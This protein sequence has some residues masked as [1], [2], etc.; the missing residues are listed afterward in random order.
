MEK[1]VNAAE[2]TQ[3][4]ETLKAE[5][6][7]SAT[8]IAQLETAKDQAERAVAQA[9]QARANAETARAQAER[10]SAADRS[11]LEGKTR[12][13]EI[14]A[15]AAIAGLVAVLAINAL[16]LMRRRASQATEEDISEVDIRPLSEPSSAALPEPQPQPR[17][18]HLEPEPRAEPLKTETAPQY[19]VDLI[20]ENIFGRELERHVARIN[21]LD[22][23]TDVTTQREA[24][25]AL[26]KPS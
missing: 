11:A 17:S 12:W 22:D 15:Y 19:R 5:L 4:I 14:L 24:Q 3:T 16:L 9:Q 10:A 26:L 20:S 2:L 1:E 8:K 25:P 21:A 18:D 7:S 6:A 13:F 23:E